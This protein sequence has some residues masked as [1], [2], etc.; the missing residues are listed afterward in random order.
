MASNRI[1]IPIKDGN[2]K[3]STI[4]APCTSPTDGTITNFYAAVDAITLGKRQGASLVTETPK[5]APDVGLAPANATR[6]N[7]WLCTYQDNVDASIHH[8]EI[9]TADL[10]LQASPSNAMDLTTGAGGTFKAAF[11]ALVK[12]PAYPGQGGG[13]AV[14]LLSVEAVGRSLNPG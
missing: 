7:K 6:N 8:L 2:G 10:L 14:T 5:D 9:P 12:S 13:N 1:L 3:I 11:D 4:T